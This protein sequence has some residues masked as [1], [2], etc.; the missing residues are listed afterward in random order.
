MEH[1]TLVPMITM[2]GESNHREE[3]ATITI[4]HK[5]GESL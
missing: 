1:K 5:T 4:I 2:E 3:I